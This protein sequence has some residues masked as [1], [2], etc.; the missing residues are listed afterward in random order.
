MRALACATHLACAACA[1]DAAGPAE[2]A[3]L[4]LEVEGLPALDPASEGSYALWIEAAGSARRAAVFNG[5]TAATRIPFALPVAR[6]VRAFIT[7]EP[8]GDRDDVPSRFVFLEGSFEGARAELRLEGSVTNGQPLEAQ[9]GAHSLFTSSNN[10]ALGY[11][12][13]ENAGL[14]LFNI[15]PSQNAHGT[16]EVKLTPL[17][18][19][20]TYEG[21]IVLRHGS[22]DAVWISYGKY[23]P[24]EHGLLTSRDNTGSGPFSGDVDYVNAGIEDV[25]GDE[26][27]TN[28]FELAVP[29]GLTLPLMLDAVDGGG[30]AVWTHVITVE[31]AFDESEPLGEERPFVPLYANPIGAGGPQMPRRILPVAAVPL[32][33]IASGDP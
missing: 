11:P 5:G 18:A 25:P 17:R 29:D 26:W 15:F 24:D 31:P 23:R 19:A 16:R 10:V 22:T 2:N 14:W 7:L 27:T 32:G 33:R 12:S 6:P 9:P 4:V 30:A 8:A 13:F 28:L 20:W 21:W 3:A 1:G